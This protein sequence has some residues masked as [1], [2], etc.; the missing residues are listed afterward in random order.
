MNIIYMGYNCYGVQSASKLYFNK[1][2]SELNLAQCA[3]LAGITNA[4][5]IYDPFT[6][7]GIKRNKKRQQTISEHSSPIRE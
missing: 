3:S 2:V 7:K 1:D 5:S 4:P 6:T